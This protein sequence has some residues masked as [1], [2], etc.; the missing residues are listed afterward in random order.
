MSSGAGSG[1]AP[2]TASGA[3]EL[4]NLDSYLRSKGLLTRQHA[5]AFAT[6]LA[7]VAHRQG[8]AVGQKNAPELAARLSASGYD[9]AVAEECAEYDECGVY[10]AAYGAA[11]VDIEYTRGAY[12]EA[13]RDPR[14]PTTTLR[15]REVSP[16]GRSGLRG[17]TLLTS[18]DWLTRR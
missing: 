8:L 4:D 3:V 10:T 18:R 15:D 2:T 6:A 17:R 11:V 13:C 5:L 9:F 1:A 16:S 14:R 12:L 7:E